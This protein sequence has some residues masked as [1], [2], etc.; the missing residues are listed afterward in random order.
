M[1][2]LNE[3]EVAQN[4]WFMTLYGPT[5][6]GK[7]ITIL[8]KSPAPIMF[9]QTEPRSLKP[10]LNTSGR[11]GEVEGRTMTPRSAARVGLE[12]IL[13]EDLS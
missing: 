7:A 5:G 8:Q 10:L 2:I 9:I 11:P 6:V 12:E 4:R 3:Q 13:H 1:K